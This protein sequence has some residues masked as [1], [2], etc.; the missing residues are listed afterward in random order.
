MITPHVYYTRRNR[1]KLK[2]YD[3][4]IKFFRSVV[5]WFWVEHTYQIAHVANI[6]D[7]AK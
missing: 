7:M 2:N 6:L 5:G 4:G 3:F 1:N